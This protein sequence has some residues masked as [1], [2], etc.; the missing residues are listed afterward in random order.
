MG[1]Q[2]KLFGAELRRARLAAGLSLGELA[3]IVHYSKGYLSKIE[4]GRK[5]PSVD[6]ARRCDVALGTDGRLGELVGHASSKT[7]T[8]GV[9]SP[10]AQDVEG[11][12]WMMSLSPQGAGWFAPMNRRDALST[13]AAALL[14]LGVTTSGGSAA[15]GQEPTYDA[16]VAMFEL[17][18][19][20]GRMMSPAAVLPGVIAQTHTLRELAA[21]AEP[22]A[23][24]RLL[25]LAARCAEFTGWMAQEAGH[26]RAAMWWTRTAVDM[27]EAAGDQELAAHGLVRTALVALLRE[28]T[29]QTVELA[30]RA[31]ADTGVSPRVRGL[32]AL[33][34]AQGHALAGDD[35]RC[36]RALDRAAV[37]LDRA[38][39]DEPD[40]G[41]ALGPASV[42][43]IG[44][45]VA[46]WCL[47][48]LGRPEQAAQIL[49]YRVPRI[50]PG[51]AKA[52]FGARRVLAHAAAGELDHAC[53]LAGLVLDEAEM[54]DSATI[55][56]DLRQ[57]SRTL[58]RWRN[59]GPVQE[60]QPRLAA[61]LHVPFR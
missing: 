20:L 39:S 56:V 23:Q 50:P 27:A 43:D 26:D 9:A 22:P 36:H 40:G 13:G 16:F 5:P 1:N 52:R 42:A 14:T 7:A 11:E 59:H 6:L 33:R 55:R 31:Q 47:Y 49:D 15:T 21:A 60:L 2:P 8:P 51:R 32:A 17:H 29:V 35:G 4:T 48:D 19:Q 37:L 57:L 18:R 53:H 54:V 41:L 25:W 45:V 61:A 30:G 28:D 38:R 44:S 12:V 58:T 3:G 34:E 10:G 46:G 24:D